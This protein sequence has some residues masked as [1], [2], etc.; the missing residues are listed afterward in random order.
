MRRTVYDTRLVS[1]HGEKNL[2]V[3]GHKSGQYVRLC[4]KDVSVGGQTQH[5]KKPTEA[6]YMQPF[7]KFV[8]DTENCVVIF[9][10]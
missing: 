4:L 7:Q 8:S 9:C 3:R 1:V 6:E 5:A 2:F 10:C